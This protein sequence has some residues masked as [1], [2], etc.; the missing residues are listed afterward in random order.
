MRQKI[1]IAEVEASDEDPREVP[2]CAGERGV[3]AAAGPD[4]RQDLPAHLRRVPRP[5]PAAPDRGVPGPARAARTESSCSPDRRRPRA[6][7]A[8]A[9]RAGIARAARAGPCSPR[10]WSRCRVPARARPDRRRA[11]ADPTAATRPPARARRRPSHPEERPAGQRRKQAR[12][13]GEPTARRSVS[14]RR[15]DLRLRRQRS[16]TEPVSSRARSP[17]RAPSGASGCG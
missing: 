8:S 13:A 16:G 10:S 3:R 6:A 1:D 14:R 15:P 17:S 9:P 12:P 7:G 5:R 2:A 4:L 11:T